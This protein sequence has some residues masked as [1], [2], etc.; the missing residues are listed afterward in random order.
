MTERDR[1][2]R[3]LIKENCESYLKF[4]FGV[5]GIKGKTWMSGGNFL[6]ILLFSQ[7]STNYL[8]QW[9]NWMAK[10]ANRTTKA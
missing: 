7:N 10:K 3:W 2:M 5:G 9:S 4:L 1:F 8:F 6:L